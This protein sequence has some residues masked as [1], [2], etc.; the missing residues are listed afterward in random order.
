M[1]PINNA[2]DGSFSISIS[3]D[4]ES[5]RLFNKMDDYFRQFGNWQ[6]I[7]REIAGLIADGIGDQL[8]QGMTPAGTKWAKLSDYMAEKTGRSSMD[9]PTTS[10]IWNAYVFHPRVTMY[11]DSVVYSPSGIPEIYHLALRG[12]WMTPKGVRVPGREWFGIS[13]E[14]FSKIVAMQNEYTTEV[15]GKYFSP[16]F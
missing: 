16:G 3:W 11:K 2:V 9:I 1:A 12:G 10:P 8:D 15:F 7:L 6:P 13:K 14:T 5:V 4:A